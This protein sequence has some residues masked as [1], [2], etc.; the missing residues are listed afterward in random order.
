MKKRS[1]GVL[2]SFRLSYRVFQTCAFAK[3]SPE[4]QNP[5]SAWL[6]FFFKRSRMVMIGL[7]N[8]GLLALRHARVKISR[9]VVA[10][11]ISIHSRLSLYPPGST[12]AAGL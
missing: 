11:Y 2:A 4:P 10:S 3:A 9:H 6:Q 1:F 7:S 12:V 8:H 5:R